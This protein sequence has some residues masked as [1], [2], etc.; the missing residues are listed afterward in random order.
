MKNSIFIN[1]YT[2]IK[3]E[4]SQCIPEDSVFVGLDASSRLVKLPRSNSRVEVLK[5]CR[6]ALDEK[7]EILIQPV[8]SFTDKSNYIELRIPKMKRFFKKQI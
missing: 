2:K 6:E 1:K 4:I 7:K 5:C 8:M 3:D